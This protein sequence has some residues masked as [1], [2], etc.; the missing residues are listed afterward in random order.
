MNLTLAK[1]KDF[2][3]YKTV[4]VTILAVAIIS[5]IIQLIYFFNLRVDR[6]HQ[7]L[8]TQNFL[9]GHGI[10]SVHVLPENLSEIIY[11]PLIKWPPGYSFLLTPFYSLFNHNYIAAGITLDI[12]FAIILIFVTREILKTLQSPI[13]V[14]NLYTILTSFIIYSFYKKSSSDAIAITLFLTGLYFTLRLLKTSQSC[15]LKTFGIIISLSICAFTKYLYMPIVFIIPFFLIV[16]GWVD[17]NKL[18]KKT[19]ILSFSVMAAAV[20]ILLLYQKNISGTAVYITEPTRGFFP[21][22]IVSLFP[23]IPA[24]FINP[25]T[26]SIL[27]NQESSINKPEYKVFQFINILLAFWGI[28]YMLLLLYKHGIKKITLPVNFLYLFFFITIAINSLLILLSL[29][30]AKEDHIWT[31]VQDPRYFG[32]PLVLLQLALFVFFRH[33]LIKQNRI[34]KFFFFIIFFLLFSET[35]RGV[36]FTSKRLVNYKKETYSWKQDLN[37]QQFT[38]AILLKEQ[39]KKPVKHIVFA[40]SSPYIYNR[41]SLYSH[42]PVMDDISRINTLSSLNTKTSVLLLVVLREDALKDF[43]PF[44]SLK[45]KEDAGHFAGFYFYTVY[46]EPH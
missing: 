15:K 14:T 8:A 46:V 11:Q 31:Y 1:I 22:N 13:Y 18:L 43:A 40:C 10:S 44:L 28:R 36:F 39:H 12:L 30:V 29:R 17:N 9:N 3:S 24:S 16:K 35:I 25:D 42:I 2:L 5:R 23:L 33:R 21:E 37:F 7:T 45:E 41:I 26:I 32:L 27:L 34:L 4:T 20:T 6:S 19:G 38:Q